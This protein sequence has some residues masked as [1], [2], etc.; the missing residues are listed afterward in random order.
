MRASF[1]P[2]F[3]IRPVPYNTKRNRE[4]DRVIY[5]RRGVCEPLEVVLALEE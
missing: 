2:F 4:R 1:L 3:G 5:G